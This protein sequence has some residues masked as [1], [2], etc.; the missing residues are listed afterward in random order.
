MVNIN[1][2]ASEITKAIAE[3]TEEVKEEIEISRKEVAQ[4]LVKELKRTSPRRPGSGKYA[5]GWRMK[6]TR[7]GWIIHNKTFYQLTHLLEKGHAKK[8]GGRVPAV[9]HIRPAEQRAV[10]EYLSRVEKAIR[11]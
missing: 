3:Y 1:N 7:R 9:V 6:Q 2:F 11:K 4:D 5:K 10:T 8:N